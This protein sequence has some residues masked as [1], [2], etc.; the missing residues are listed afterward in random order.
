VTIH[1]LESCSRQ[2]PLSS[3]AAVLA[4]SMLFGTTGT[5]QALGPPGASALA[6]GA[7]RLLL[8]GIALVAVAFFF[9]PRQKRAWPR[10]APALLMGG[11]AVA[12][13]QLGWFA[14]LRR[15][16]VALGTVVGIGSGPVMA[17]VLHLLRRRG[18]LTRAWLLGTAATVAGAGLLAARGAGESATDPLGLLLTLCAVLGY[19]LSVEAAQHAM[20]RGLD[21]AGAMAGIFGAGA[22]L[23]VPVL[24]LEPLAWVATAP[25]AA[26]ALHLG[27]VTLALAYTLYGWGLRGLAVPTVV[28]LTLAEPLTAAVLG[29]ALLGERLGPSGWLGA[30]LIAAGLVLAA[31]GE[32]KPS[33]AI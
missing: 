15:T 29:T 5:A 12:V 6:I 21:P 10:H 2:S 27:L 30:A 13:Y 9:R 3:T 23:L 14:G 7:V 19:V 25:G 18:R 1:S 16:G 11:A 33:A 26:M 32:R 20:S 8:G 17:G 22:L 28:T 24:A 4:A 31:R